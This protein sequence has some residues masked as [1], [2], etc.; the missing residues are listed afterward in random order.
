M[1]QFVQDPVAP[2][3]KAVADGYGVEPAELIMLG[4]FDSI[5]Q[6]G[7]EREI[8]F[9]RAI[10]VVGVILVV[11]TILLDGAIQFGQH[12]VRKLQ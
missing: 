4:V 9:D 5:M 7:R 12:R 8:V 6:C 11:G 1:T 3:R 10:L 2:L